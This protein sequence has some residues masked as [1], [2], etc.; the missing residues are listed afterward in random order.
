MLT[1][2][3]AINKIS[4]I[5]LLIVIA[6]AALPSTSAYVETIELTKNDLVFQSNF[7]AAGTSYSQL[8]GF[9]SGDPIRFNYSIPTSSG[10]VVYA[11]AMVSTSYGTRPNVKSFGIYKYAGGATSGVSY[12]E[13]TTKTPS[14]DVQKYHAP[15]YTMGYASYGY[16]LSGSKNV[17]STSIDFDGPSV[18][19]LVDYWYPNNEYV[20]DYAEVQVGLDFSSVELVLHRTELNVESHPYTGTAPLTVS[21][22][23]EARDGVEPYTFLWDFGNYTTSLKDPTYTFNDPGTY[24]VICRVTDSVGV[25]DV[26]N[27]TI[28]VYPLTLKIE[29][30]G[31]GTTSPPPGEYVKRLGDQ[32]QVTAIPA[33]GSSLDV[34]LLDGIPSGSKSTFNVIMDSN[35]TLKAKFTSG[36]Q[37]IAS[38]NPTEGF[39]PLNVTFTSYAFG[40][41]TPYSYNWEFGDFGISNLQNPYHIYSQP[42]SYMAKVVAVDSVGRKGYSEVGPISVFSIFDFTLTKERDIALKPGESSSTRIYLNSSVTI[43]VYLSLEWI[44]SV[45]VASAVKISPSSSL[46]NFT[47]VLSIATSTSTPV[48]NYVCL[49]KGVAGNITRSVEVNIRISP[50]LYTLDLRS[51]EGGTTSPRPGIY[52]FSSGQ[53]VVIEA[54]P[55]N[56]YQFEGWELDGSPYG[57]ANLL[58]LTMFCNHTVKANFVA[59]PKPPHSSVTLDVRYWDGNTW[60]AGEYLTYGVLSLSDYGP[61]LSNPATYTV[62]IGEALGIQ[63]IPRNKDGLLLDT[64]GGSPIG[65]VYSSY[66]T[67]GGSNVEIPPPALTYPNSYQFYITSFSPYI[68]RLN[69]KWVDYPVNIHSET[70]NWG[71]ITLISSSPSLSLYT[72]W[73]NS[74]GTYFIDHGYD[75]TIRAHPYSGYYFDRMSVDGETYYSEEVTISRVQEPHDITVYFTPSPPTFTLKISATEGGTTMP[76][77]G[78]Y[79]LPRYSSYSVKALVTDQRF[80]FSTWILDGV[81]FGS[82]EICSVYMA[83]D[84]ELCAV[85]DSDYMNMEEVNVGPCDILSGNLFRRVILGEFFGANITGR[86]PGITSPTEVSVTAWFDCDGAYY[87]DASTSRIE[88]DGIL[89]LEG[90]TTTNASGWFTLKIGSLD[91]KCWVA[92]ENPGTYFAYADIKVGAS[93]TAYKGLWRSDNVTTIVNFLYDLSGTDANFLML[94]SDGTPVKNRAGDYIFG[95]K[96]WDLGLSTSI[97]NNG[98]ATMR[99]PYDKLANTPYLESHWTTVLYANVSGRLSSVTWYKGSSVRYTE[100]SAQFLMHN[101][102]FLLLEIFDWGSPQHSDIGGVL[103]YIWL[104]EPVEWSGSKGILTGSPYGPSTVAPLE[105]SGNNL[106]A[107]DAL[108]NSW[109]IHDYV[110]IPQEVTRIDSALFINHPPL[111]EFLRNHKGELYLTL[112]PPC[113]TNVLY[114]PAKEGIVLLAASIPP[115]EGW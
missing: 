83:S 52:H 87:W 85:F 36:L 93:Q 80:T 67:L 111:E 54:I 16:T 95:F 31:E 26:K 37:V 100:I 97:D 91:T 27:L 96:E 32:V 101:E 61:V 13:W 38:A 12:L 14:I 23:A 51:G 112:I 28:R 103:A 2:K 110:K 78:Y 50:A 113:S 4:I 58:T 76:S 69:L 48:G 84:H 11:Y 62:N 109:E 60:R 107:V 41:T 6:L 39:P 25:S 65:K 86:L 57:S 88:K 8:Y 66:Y 82:T 77:P 43:P 10:M 68:I 34:W 15:P 56:D 5:L 3:I 40:G 106:Y 92:K 81:P 45:P 64:W 33:Q 72:R 75:V 19:A 29:T 49:V 73:F 105:R 22:Y 63:F 102:T 24:T 115:P 17:G 46:T 104:D 74:W 9:D 18:W 79:A 71:Y 59:V 35:H 47:S 55:D 94:F 21:F 108:G 44:G 7:S 98:S 114:S 89:R 90:R 30:E 42:G 1:H 99:I 53:N 70:P 20:T